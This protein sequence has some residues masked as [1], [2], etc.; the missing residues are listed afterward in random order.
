MEDILEYT[1]QL[2]EL[3]ADYIPNDRMSISNITPRIMYFDVINNLELAVKK[4]INSE[5]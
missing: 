4:S 1:K 5:K 3:F 2:R